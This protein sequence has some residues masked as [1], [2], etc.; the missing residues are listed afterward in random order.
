[1]APLLVLIAVVSLF[2]MLVS[3]DPYSV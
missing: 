2:H 1:L 3:A